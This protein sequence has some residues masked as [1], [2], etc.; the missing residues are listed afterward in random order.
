MIDFRKLKL[1]K[2]LLIF[3]F[4]AMI[5]LA[6]LQFFNYYKFYSLSEEKANYYSENMINQIY[7]ELNIVLSSIEDAAYTISYSRNTQEYLY[8]YDVE[9]RLSLTAAVSDL[10]EYINSTNSNISNIKLRME[11]NYSEIYSTK[12]DGYIV[13]KEIEDKYNFE[14]ENF[15]K[16]TFTSTILDSNTR[17]LSFG[18]IY[19]VYSIINGINKGEKA[20]ACIIVY[21][22]N[23]I[24]KIIDNI[25]TSKQSHFLIV[26]NENT[27][28]AA[29]DNKLIG[30]KLK[31]TFE[32]GTDNKALYND[33]KALVQHKDV[34]KI[35]WKIY[36][37]IPVGELTS[38]MKTIRDFDILVGLI[39]LVLMLLTGLLIM[40]NITNPILNLIEFTKSVGKVNRKKRIQLDY[41]NEVG[42]L[43]KY[44]NKM[45][46]DLEN[47][48]LKIFNTQQALYEAELVRNQAI[49]EQK[50][51]ELLSLQSQINPHFLYN[52]LECIRS[53]GV[54]ND[55]IEIEEIANSLAKIFRYC[56]KGSEMVSI[57]DEYECIKDYMKIMHIRF[58]G[59]FTTRY[60]INESI[61]N[62]KMIKMILQP[63]VENAIYH[64]LEC[65][66]EPGE[67]V[68][69]GDVGENNV[70][71][72]SISD[73]GVGMNE[74][75][76]LSLNL[77]LE[78]NCARD[79]SNK[80]IGLVNINRRIKLVYGDEYGIRV[81][82]S[83]NKG[84]TVLLNFPIT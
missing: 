21:K 59:K 49:I 62:K 48:N 35:G 19:P 10:L 13:M 75:Q 77:S 36:N 47:T 55:I 16:S 50:Q 71:N 56:I 84:T 51:A 26:D 70:V 78:N 3:T 72:I 76:L 41:E 8:S 38:E 61:M 73:N 23:T 65:M 1:R 5:F 11:H 81:E 68:I 9:R 14:D 30:E 34:E 27:I 54:A 44:I 63:I 7:N 17:K 67:L 28:I 52:T 82:S 18:Y 64:G 4:I 53:F 6:L 2:Q 45:L 83:L 58:A 42:I 15:R 37:I 20:G 46:D 24:Q 69:I 74:E 66:D 33:K 29:N 40:N 22:I 43:A 25:S 12:V 39:L 57:A 60:E 32:N 79:N 31:L 80:N